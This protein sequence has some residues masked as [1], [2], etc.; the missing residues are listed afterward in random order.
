[1]MKRF[2]E[3]KARSQGVGI[4]AAT[5]LK[6]TARSLRKK[7]AYAAQLIPVMAAYHH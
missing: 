7:L 1:M 4:R 2:S 6:S 5:R 3:E